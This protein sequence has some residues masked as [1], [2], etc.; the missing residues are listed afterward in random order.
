MVFH[1]GIRS[2]AVKT[3]K[4]ASAEPDKD[5]SSPNK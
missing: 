2:I 1:P 3:A 5:L 4:R